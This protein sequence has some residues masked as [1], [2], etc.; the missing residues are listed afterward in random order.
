MMPSLAPPSNLALGSDEWN[1]KVSLSELVGPAT[2]GLPPKGW[3]VAVGAGGCH[4]LP[5]NR[6]ARFSRQDPKWTAR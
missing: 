4:H 1:W 6:R 5:G 3:L 2:G